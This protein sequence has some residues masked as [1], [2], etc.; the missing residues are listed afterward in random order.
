MI[1]FSQCFNSV[2]LMALSIYSETKAKFLSAETLAS[3]GKETPKEVQIVY[4]LFLV[5]CYLLHGNIQSETEADRDRSIYCLCGR[6]SDSLKRLCTTLVMT[7]DNL[8]I[9]W[10]SLVF[11][12]ISNQAC[13]KPTPLSTTVSTATGCYTTLR[14]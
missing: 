1:F 5:N 7:R 11:T 2:N 6:F 13:F 9:F 12:I 4:R 3:K 8:Y 14:T 10:I